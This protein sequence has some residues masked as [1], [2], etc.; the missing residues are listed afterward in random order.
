[1]IC[2]SGCNFNYGR[3]V[4]DFASSMGGTKSIKFF[5]VQ[6]VEVYSGFH[7]QGSYI[8]DGLFVHM[9]CWSSTSCRSSTSENSR[10]TIVTTKSFNFYSIINEYLWVNYTSTSRSESNIKYMYVDGNVDQDVNYSIWGDHYTGLANE[11]PIRYLVTGRVTSVTI[12]QGTTR[13]FR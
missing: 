10:T 13:M 6:S 9:G 12:K 3:K 4:F 1:M 2:E 8:P 5:Y 7:F 11:S